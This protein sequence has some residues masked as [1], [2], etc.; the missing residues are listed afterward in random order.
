MAPAAPG[1]S[2][3]PA[4]GGRRRMALQNQRR[5]VAPTEHWRRPRNEYAHHSPRDLSALLAPDISLRPVAK[6]LYEDESVTEVLI[7]GP[8]NIYVERSGKLQKIDARFL[9]EEVLLAAVNNLAEYV[10]RRVDELHHSMDARL[11]EPE[12]FRVHVIIPPCSRNGVV[13]SIR[14]SAARRTR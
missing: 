5:L 7:N 6:V 13:V 8:D 11:P 12:Q 14:S 10:D 9:S 2:A 1:D 3:T 4:A